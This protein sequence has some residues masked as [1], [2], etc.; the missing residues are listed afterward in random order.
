MARLAQVFL[1]LFVAYASAGKGI[2]NVNSA[3]RVPSEY[4]V[5]VKSSNPVQR[6]NAVRRI[7]QL[8]SGVEIK[9]RFN[10]GKLSVLLIQAEEES[11]VYSLTSIQGVQS[12]EANVL[13]N[14][15]QCESQDLTRF[16]GLYNLA[17][18]NV[19]EAGGP[20]VYNY[21]QDDGAGTTVYVLDTGIFLEHNDFGGRA[22]HG[23]TVA[24]ID[25]NEGDEDLNGHG[26]HCAGT[27][28][29]STYGAAKAA[30]A[31]A[32]KVVNRLGMGTVAQCI[33]GLEWVFNDFQ[34]RGGQFKAVISMSLGYE[35]SPA[36]DSLIQEISDAGL[37]TV[38]AAGN[39]YS[40]ACNPSPSGA[41]ASLSVAAS[42]ASDRLAIFTNTGECVDII[43]PG[44]NILSAGIRDEDS[45]ATMSGTSMSCPLVAGVVLRYMSQVESRPSP[46]EIRQ[47]FVQST[48]K[49]AIDLRG[50]DE[51]PNHFLYAPCD[52]Q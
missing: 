28:M 27:V 9:K 33:D 48:T 5:T 38:A 43:A 6:D 18:T 16:D 22:S 51:T 7:N 47:V 25:V 29:G 13:K 41:E 42:D 39:E 17:R 15:L 46:E 8:G 52:L 30:N 31:I 19:R 44:V 3:N 45:S 10:V 4:L 14:V 40:S 12:V 24:P 11:S 21:R 20:S 35:R 26:T 37:L 32:V 50:Y 2:Q 23:Y 1:V 34:G 49:D 36:M